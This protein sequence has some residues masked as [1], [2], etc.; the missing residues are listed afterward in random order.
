[1]VPIKEMAE[2]GGRRRSK[3]AGHAGGRNFRKCWSRILF[4]GRKGRG[5]IHR[6]GRSR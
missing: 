6:R 5:S 4:R 1:M 2:E 3:L